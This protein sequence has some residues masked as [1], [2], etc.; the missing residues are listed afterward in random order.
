MLW[1]V[2]GRLH[3][4]SCFREI[5]FRPSEFMPRFHRALAELCV[6]I[7]IDSRFLVDTGGIL[8]GMSKSGVFSPTY[9]IPLAKR[10]AST[11]IESTV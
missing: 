7:A 8:S 4:K 3:N 1:P 9:S 6:G 2:H 5:A 11:D 10:I